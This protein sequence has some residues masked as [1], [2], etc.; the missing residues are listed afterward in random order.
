MCLNLIHQNGYGIPSPPR[1]Y[2]NFELNH[3]SI[4]VTLRNFLPYNTET[5][6]QSIHPSNVLPSSPISLQIPSLT[7]TRCRQPARLP[8]LAL[9]MRQNSRS[10]KPSTISKPAFQI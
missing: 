7:W 2:C 1:T 3:S 8:K 4:T 9:P 5:F 6:H 10:L